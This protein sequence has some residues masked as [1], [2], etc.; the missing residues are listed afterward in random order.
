[1]ADV[2]QT[3]ANFRINASGSRKKEVQAGETVTPGMPLYENADGKYYKSAATSATLAAS[4]GVCKDYG[5][6]DDYVDIVQ[7][8]ELDMGGTLVLG[9]IYLVSS[10]AG[11]IMPSGDLTTGEFGHILGMASAAGNLKLINQSTTEFL[12]GS[13]ARA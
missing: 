12:T 3:A 4:K 1:M 8:G 2:T 9:E 11:G 6:A 10:T 5:D 13:I 7:Q